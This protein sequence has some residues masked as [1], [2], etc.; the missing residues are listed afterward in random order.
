MVLSARAVPRSYK[1]G[2]WD[3]QVSSVW[4]SVKERVSWK[5][6]TIQRE[7]EHGSCRIF[8][9]RSRYQGMADEDNV[10]WKILACAVVICKVWRLAMEL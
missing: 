7:L 10:G 6:S 1:E 8:T 3:N 5:G 4:E 2:S 9:V